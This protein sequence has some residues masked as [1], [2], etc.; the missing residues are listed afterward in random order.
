MTE[1]PPPTA[2]PADLSPENRPEIRT[3]VLG[4]FQTNCYIVCPTDPKPGDPCWVADVGF[5]P[6]PMLDEIDRLQ[7]EPEAVVLTHAHLDHM[8][9]LLAF[10]RRFPHTPIWIHEAEEDWLNDPVL[11]LS[12]GYGLEITGPTPDR[13]LQDGEVL[14]LA[15][16]EWTVLHTPGHSPGGISLV[17]KRSPTAI[18]G[19]T[20]FAGSIGR[21]DFPGS[22][23]ATLAKSIRQKLYTL[24]NDT[25]ALPG[26]GPATQ[27]GREKLTNPFVR[28]DSVSV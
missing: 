25:I 27:I 1:V 17:H 12:A 14:T 3:A 23:F 15:G 9:G 28:E 20:L 11:N 10:R 4:P 2:G 19:D 26:H 16:E 18:V 8:A 22:D 5:E 6:K 13:L 24:P 7:L 21:H